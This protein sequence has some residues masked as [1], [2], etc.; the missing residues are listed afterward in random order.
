MEIKEFADKLFNTGKR[1]G[2]SD[3]EIYHVASEEFEVTAFEREISTY[4]IN[5]DIGLSFR[6]IIDG[7]MGYS[8][9]EKFEDE[10]I[11]F[12]VKSA[13]QNAVEIEN[14][15]ELSIFEGSK[16]YRTIENNELKDKEVDQKIK[17]A[18][19]MEENALNYDKRIKSARY[20]LVSTGS[21]RR[22]II[23]TKGLNLTESS[24][25]A[26][27]YLS[28]VAQHNDDVKMGSKFKLSSNYSNINFD[29]I[30]KEAAD[31]AMSKLGA[32]SVKS[33]KYKIILRHDA[34]SDLLSTFLSIFSSDA[35]QKG[36]SLL[37]GKVGSII[38]SQAVSIIEDPFHKDAPSSCG[39]DDEGVATCEKDI[40][41]D[42]VLK[43]LLYNIKTA[44]KDGTISTGNGFKA[45]YKSPVGISPTNMYIKP[46]KRSYEEAIKALDKA[47]IIT[48]LQGLH[49]GA[50]PVSGD[51]SLAAEGFL[52]ENGAVTRPIEQI[53]VADNFYNVLM[54]VE[55][56]L[57]DFEFNLPSHG[58]IGSGSLVLTEMTITGE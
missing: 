44:K 42:G 30:V 28:L 48:D 32:K 6:G 33:G 12:L 24:G 55:E 46:G 16:E 19:K 26:I 45:S 51:F 22:S 41:K 11:E 8:Y 53:T 34:A 1:H 47:I 4:K 40:I 29:E 38:A 27:A 36:L 7:K 2:F 10:D 5:T 31:I 54:N 58:T 57:S 14:D 52:V 56:V 21:G 49:S 3:M 9:T 18:L 37:K 20:C 25:L 43:T 15:V 39:F 50:N 23:N 13:A 35:A 17:D